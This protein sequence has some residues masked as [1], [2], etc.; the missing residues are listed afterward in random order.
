MQSPAPQK[1]KIAGRSDSSEESTDDTIENIKVV[2]EEKDKKKT[3]DDVSSDLSDSTITEV[4]ED[5]KDPPETDSGSIKKAVEALEL[6]A[7][8]VSTSGV[9]GTSESS[10]SSSSSSTVGSG[11]SGDISSSDSSVS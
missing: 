8:P 10:S 1:Q 2:T 3:D 5:Y 4:K 9:V 11:K 6:L 7:I